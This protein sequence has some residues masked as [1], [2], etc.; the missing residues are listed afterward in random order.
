MSHFTTV[1]AEIK[2]LEAMRAA[3][4][5]MGFELKENVECRYFSGSP[6][7]ELVIKLPG[8]YDAALEK[9]KDGTFRLSA[10]FWGGHVAEYIGE[11]G[12]KLMQAYA[13]EKAKIEA[14][15]RGFSVTE[16]TEGNDLL[17]SIRDSQGGTLKA[18]IGPDGHTTFQ[19]SGIKGKSCMK[20][21]ELEKSLG[22][23]EEHMVTGDYYAEDEVQQEISIKGH[24]LCG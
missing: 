9:Q 24:F 4:A 6:V 22:A 1:N 2:D 19:P 14:R 8:K 5:R 18:W 21:M 23:V 13:A 12:K 15:K 7:K 3:V 10:D 20:F 11:E 16:R 17:L